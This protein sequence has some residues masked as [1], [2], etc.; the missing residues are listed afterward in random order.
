MLRLER[1][2]HALQNVP[3][4]GR[5]TYTQDSLQRPNLLTDL[6][7]SSDAGMGTP[8]HGHR[9]DFPSVHGVSSVLE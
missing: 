4:A 1:S 5:V 2:T 3:A 8:Y 6:R 9:N 7:R